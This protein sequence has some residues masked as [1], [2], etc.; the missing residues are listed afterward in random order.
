[1]K[2]FS[3]VV[4]VNYN[5]KK[6]LNANWK[7]VYTWS[8]TRTSLADF[9]TI[10]GKILN[11]HSLF[12][13]VEGYSKKVSESCIFGAYNR[14]TLVQSNNQYKM[15]TSQDNFGFGVIFKN[16]QVSFNLK[17]DQS[18]LSVEQN[19]NL[20]ELVIAG[21]FVRVQFPNEQILPQGIINK[22]TCSSFEMSEN[23]QHISD[24]KLS[25]IEIWAIDGMQAVDDDNAQL[26]DQANPISTIYSTV[27]NKF[28]SSTPL[29]RCREH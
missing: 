10:I 24:L 19:E 20:N 8:E 13:I 4:N 3:K 26:K 29:G 21:G 22:D 12:I 27:R 7:N 16:E 25:K 23:Y 18:I 1:M 17:A 28:E 15:L 5:T 14:N 11:K 9:D 6:L 2:H